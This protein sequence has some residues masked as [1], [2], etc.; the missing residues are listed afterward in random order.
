MD[1]AVGHGRRR[2]L[3]TRS[4]RVSRSSLAAVTKLLSHIEG[5]VS[6][7]DGGIPEGRLDRERAFAFLSC[8][9]QGA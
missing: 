9:K 6:V 7:Q 8:H 3:H 4:C 5:V 1:F 2:K